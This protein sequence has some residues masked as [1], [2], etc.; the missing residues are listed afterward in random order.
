VTEILDKLPSTGLIAV[1]LLFVVLHFVE[2]ML[3]RFMGRGVG[4]SA[5]VVPLIDCPLREQVEATVERAIEEQFTRN[6]TIRRAA[7]LERR[8][9]AVEM[10]ERDAS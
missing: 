10:R 8:L 3:N 6:D 5:A 2:R 9:S 7:D 1:A 4:H